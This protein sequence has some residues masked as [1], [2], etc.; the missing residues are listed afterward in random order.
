M[1]A[2]GLTGGIGSGKS[3]CAD[4]FEWL[5]I[6][7]YRSDAE[8]KRLMVSDRKLIGDII[9]LFG[10]ESYLDDG[11]LNSKFLSQ[12]IFADKDML[13]KMNNCVHPAVRRDFAKWAVK[14]QKHRR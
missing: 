5:G 4:I 7:V 14:H 10:P 11:K 12:V 1:L 9:S 6:P 2:V 3:F 8:A 13:R